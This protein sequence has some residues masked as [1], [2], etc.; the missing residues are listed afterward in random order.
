MLV[1]LSTRSLLTYAPDGLRDTGKY[2]LLTPGAWDF[3]SALA[4]D[5]A[6]HVACA[7]YARGW[8]RF[9][10]RRKELWAQGT[11]V[12]PAYR[13]KGLA[14]ALWERALGLGPEVVHVDAVSEGGQALIT[15]LRRRYHGIEFL[16][17]G[18]S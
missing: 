4:D 11:W 7:S 17:G 12:E 10:F 15:S 18:R 16:S 14:T 8:F 6:T 5:D 9:T 13:G 1:R 2:R 3:L